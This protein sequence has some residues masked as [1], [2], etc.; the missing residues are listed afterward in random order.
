MHESLTMHAL[1]ALSFLPFPA[2][3]AALAHAQTPVYH[4]GGNAPGER[5]GTAVAFLPDLDGDGRD[6]ILVGAPLDSTAAPH[7]GA[8]HLLDGASGVAVQT[9]YGDAEEHR[10]GTAVAPAG[11]VDADGFV[12]VIAGAPSA[13]GKF[14]VGYARVYS[15]ATM[16][17]IYTVEGDTIV[18]WFG[19][20]VAGGGDQDLDGHADFVVGAHSFCGGFELNG[21]ARA[22]SGATGQE[23][24][25]TGGDGTWDT[26]A[27]S[28][29]PLGDFD[30]DGVPDML[31]GAP[32]SDV[33]G[34]DAGRFYI[35]S[36]VDGEKLY[37]ENG[38]AGLHYSGFS[39]CGIGDADLDGTL[40]YAIGVPGEQDGFAEGPH[41]AEFG[42]MQIMS[43][44]SKSVLWD[45]YGPGALDHHGWA[46]E[47]AG[48]LDA[49]GYPE[50]ASA[51]PR[52]DVQTTGLSLG[53][54]YV[55][56]LSTAT[57]EVV[58]HLEGPIDDEN[59]EI[60]L[61]AGGD[62][63]GDGT[64]DLILG[65]AGQTLTKGFVEVISGRELPMSAPFHVIPPSKPVELDLVIDAPDE[66]E[67]KLYR[68]LGSFSGTSPGFRMDGLSIPLNPDDYLTYTLNPSKGT[69]LKHSSGI[70]GATKKPMPRFD[71]PGDL[72]VTLV[73]VTINHVLVIFDDLGTAI[74]ASAP[75]PLTVLP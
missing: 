73:G 19:K 65:S 15:G 12:D 32:G 40:D 53:P 2:L 67:G 17:T 23:R 4:L 18:D 31:V 44:A 72:A 10:M 22:F 47:L 59:F 20:A 63:N 66:H 29:A 71:P 69:I 52:W 62:V 36:G 42:K 3:A 24:W 45:I 21:Y 38:E 9:V 55:D 26:F 75:V 64:P 56:V 61:A 14:L 37:F 11:D 39:V 27:I 48:D 1:R 49:D 13:C 68:V 8:L 35:L 58:L 25:T 57:G 34:Y 41:P 6:E 74:S 46:V 60:D 5:Y 54:A 28:V 70:L 7:A 16:E 43:G 33:A 30:L 51:A 50:V